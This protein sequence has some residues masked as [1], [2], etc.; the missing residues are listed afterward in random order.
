MKIR[1]AKLTD[2]DYII[3]CIHNIFIV[4]NKL[5]SNINPKW[6]LWN[7]YKW[8]IAQEIIDNDFLILILE[9][10]GNKIWIIS[11]D[12]WRKPNLWHYKRFSNLNFLYI[13]DEFRKKWY[14][15]ELC[16]KFF[17]WAKKK[18]S[19]RVLLNV[20]DNN[21]NA[22]KLYKKLWFE[23]NTISLWKDL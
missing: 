22:N 5:N 15:E 2:L 11:W 19:D 12:N 14:A 4:E 10:K 23:I 16:N 6:A 21:K 20:L 13:E 1:K 8:G 7:E 9:D 3:E 17:I 18:W